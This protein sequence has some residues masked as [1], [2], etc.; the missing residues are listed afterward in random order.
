MPATLRVII[1][2]IV[3]GARGG[4]SVETAIGSDSGSVSVSASDVSLE[5]LE[6]GAFLRRKLL[7]RGGLFAGLVP[8]V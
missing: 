7:P 6:M 3:V 5:G 2:L 4:S 8:V 1:L